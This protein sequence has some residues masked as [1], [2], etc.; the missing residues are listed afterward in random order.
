LREKIGTAYYNTIANSGSDILISQ[1]IPEGYRHSYYTFGAVFNG[2]KYGI[3]WQQF[4]K[5]YMEFGGDGIYAA[6]QTVNNEPAF[7]NIGWGDVP[8]SEK[9]QK[10][11]MQF[12][13]NQKNDEELNIQLNALQK[14]LI[15]FS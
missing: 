5:K 12:T 7:E 13:T 15:N 3:E 6:W 11:I 4:R 2:T 14:T 10:N 8:I 1:E 9:L